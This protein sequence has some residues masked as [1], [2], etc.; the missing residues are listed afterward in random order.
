MTISKIF[1]SNDGNDGQDTYSAAT[2]TTR[3]HGFTGNDLLFGGAG[4][5]A[6]LVARKA[7]LLRGWV[8]GEIPCGS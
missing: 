4:M 5:A 2:A 6:C 8:R 7:P 3:V 1:F